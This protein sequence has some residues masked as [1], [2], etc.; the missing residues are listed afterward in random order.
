MWPG[1]EGPRNMHAGRTGFALKT[2][3]AHLPRQQLVW[4]GDWNHALS[5]TES[6]G[7]LGGRVH[8]LDSV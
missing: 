4:G 7:S 1:A 3:L 6:A 8:V 2:L 5:G